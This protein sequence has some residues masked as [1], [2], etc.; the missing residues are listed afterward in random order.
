MD[1]RVLNTKDFGLPQNRQ[2]IFIVGERKQDILWRAHWPTPS[3]TYPSVKLKDIL[4]E[5]FDPKYIIDNPKWRKHIID[6]LGKYCFIDNEIAATMT[7]RQYSDWNGQFVIVKAKYRLSPEQIAKAKFYR[8]KT[9]TRLKN[10]YDLK[11]GAMKLTRDLD[12]QAQTVSKNASNVSRQSNLIRLGDIGKNNA[13]AQRIYDPEGLS[14]TLAGGGGGQGG[15]TGLYFVGYLDKNKRK[16]GV[17]PGTE[18]LSRSHRHRNRIYSENGLAPT[19]VSTESTN[20][21][22]TDK[23]IRRLT[24]REC[25]RLQGF[26]ESF[27]IP[28]SDSQAYKQFGNAVSVPVVTAVAKSLTNG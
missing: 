26:P 15:K 12:K 6:R 3:K 16:K 18:H 13:Q 21:I 5:Q 22:L 27:K 25:A 10:G 23:I 17:L 1:Y 28:V 20:H 24:P 14:C 2:R 7:A 19:L 9:V 11:V 8:K 4:H